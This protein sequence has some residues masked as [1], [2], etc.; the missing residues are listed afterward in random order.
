MTQLTY[1]QL[2][3][4]H[5][6][7]LTTKL[8]Y[9]KYPVRIQYPGMVRTYYRLTRDT[10]VT[11]D[12]V[13]ANRTAA[14]RAKILKDFLIVNNAEH[15]FRMDEVFSVYVDLYGA[16]L[17]LNNFKKDILTITSPANKTQEDVLLNDLTMLI[18]KS[19]YYNK[20]R[21]KIEISAVRG[22][23]SLFED[24]IDFCE[25]SL[26]RDNYKFN[27]SVGYIRHLAANNYRLPYWANGIVYLT[28]YDDLALLHLMYKDKIDKTTKITL[29]DEIE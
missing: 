26:E 22:D 3:K 16:E 24:L 1:E 7:Q 25:S 2:K 17:L 21:Y 5:R 12:H 8:F 18:R 23:F 6:W 19:L 28:E 9:N 13:L 14:H 29:L 10:T 20:F 27:S 4:H 15:R 11:T